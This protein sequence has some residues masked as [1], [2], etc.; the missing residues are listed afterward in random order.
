MVKDHLFVARPR[1]RVH[2]LSSHR[3]VATRRTASLA[4]QP[5]RTSIMF[6]NASRNARRSASSVAG[7]YAMGTLPSSSPSSAPPFENRAAVRLRHR[8]RRARISGSRGTLAVVLARR[9]RSDARRDDTVRHARATVFVA[10]RRARASDMA[11]STVTGAQP[12]P[13]ARALKK[14]RRHCEP[15]LARPRHAS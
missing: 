10:S 13:R 6:G 7:S 2:R 5:T 15:C 4:A 9:R 8:A 1:R 11:P 14:R 3:L 12:C